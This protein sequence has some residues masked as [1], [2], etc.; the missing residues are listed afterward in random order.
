MAITAPIER[1]KRE[2]RLPAVVAVTLLHGAIGYFL[3]S[4]LGI[5]SLHKTDETLKVFDVRDAPPPA[6]SPPPPQPAEPQAAP[7]EPEAR[8]GAAA[9]RAVPAPSPDPLPI[10]RLPVLSPAP[11]APVPAE[12]SAPTSGRSGASVAG[13]GSGLSGVGTGSGQSGS[14]SGGG[15][16]AVHAE[17]T[18][19]RIRKSDYPKSAYRDHAGGTVFLRIAVGADG[20]VSDCTI[21]ESSG[22]AD[23]DAATCALVRERWRY[24][25]AR[26]AAGNAVPDVVHMAQIW[27]TRPPR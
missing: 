9:R 6:P 23:L 16:V 26:D 25:P 19:G 22:R 10:V 24:Q 5:T 14:G 1:F 7:P 18:K 27:E 4:G 12:G 20:R 8:S 11:V 17:R 2:Q 15:G 21:E 13:T 3:V